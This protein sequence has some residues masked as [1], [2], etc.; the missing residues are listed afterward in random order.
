MRGLQLAPRMTKSRHKKPKIEAGNQ[1]LD[2]F[3]ENAQ[4]SMDTRNELSLIPAGCLCGEWT[5]KSR[6]DSTVIPHSR[7]GND[8]ATSSFVLLIMVLTGCTSRPGRVA[9]PRFDA[10]KAGESALELYDSDADGQL[11]KAELQKCPPLLSKLRQIDDNGDG[12]LSAAEIKQRVE[13]WLATRVGFVSGYKCKVLENGRPLGGATVEYVPE[14]FLGVAAKK[15]SGTT[16][17][18]GIASLAIAD[19]DLPDDLRGI[20]G[21]QPGMYRVRIH[22]SS[23]AVPKE[24]DEESQVGCEVYPLGDP[25]AMTFDIRKK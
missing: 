5:F 23:K 21:V 4:L 22:H 24:Y 11:S 1:L 25:E 18:A 7:L 19:V 13:A 9:S 8:L 10:T 3:N 17:S 12:R 20:R 2:I 6:S 14:E 15:A 16:D